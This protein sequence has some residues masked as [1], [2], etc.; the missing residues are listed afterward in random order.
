MLAERLSEDLRHFWP[1]GNS[2][3]LEEK[4]NLELALYK[5]HENEDFEEILFWGK[6][7]GVV[8]DYY[9]ALAV[10]YK[11]HYEFPHKRYFWS[12]NQ[13][14]T[15][16]ELPSI[17]PNDKQYV[18]QF[19][20]AFTGEHDKILVEV[21]PAE[22]QE[23]PEEEEAEKPE[24]DSLASTEEEKIPPKNFTELDRLAFVVRAIDQDCSV[25]PRGAFRMTPAHEL[26]RNHSFAGLSREELKK[27]G[28]YH[29][30]RNVQQSDKRDQLDRDDALFT[31]DFLDEIQ[32]DSPKCCWSI[33]IDASGNLATVRSLLW[34]GYASF[35][36]ANTNKFGGLYIGDGIKNAD[37]PFML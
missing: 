22:D 11:G 8:K 2:L 23:A 32:K 37:L 7:R 29:H 12:T 27:L 9:L 28:D 16:A 4:M 10:N 26:S 33:Q 36:V 21:Q 24:K 14:W 1:T 34:P 18:E 3:N 35:H 15:F 5:I 20:V 19:N 6:I 17:N 30:F 25:V 31:Y 13:N